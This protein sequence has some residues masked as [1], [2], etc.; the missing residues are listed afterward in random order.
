MS[1]A[2]P[3]RLRLDKRTMNLENLLGLFNGRDLNGVA[4]HRTVDFDVIAGKGFGLLFGRVVKFHDLAV[5]DKDRVGA[6]FHAR[7]QTLGVRLARTA[8]LSTTIGIG[9]IPRHL[10]SK[11]SNRAE[12]DRQERR[13]N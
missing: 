3:S 2:A 8:V 10:F 13:H 12:R 1:K 7:L 4:F 9:D 11:S 6:L 5:A